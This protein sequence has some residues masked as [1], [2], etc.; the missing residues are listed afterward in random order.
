MSDALVR[1]LARG[2]IEDA[3]DDL[4]FALRSLRREPGVAA[5]IIATFALAI[6]ANA[7]MVG[8]VTRLM[9]VAPPGV[10]V[11]DA[12]ARLRVE[13][14]T[15]DGDRYA[16][17]TTSY[18]V[19]WAARA[20]GDAFSRCRRGAADRLTTG[21]GADLTEVRHRR[22]RRLL[23]RPRRAAGDR[24]LLRRRRRPIAS[25]SAVAVLSH[26]YWQRR[27]GGSAAVLGD[28]SW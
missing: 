9:M 19:F 14:T 6:G 28:H 13:V 20:L 10:S 1:G 23:P 26:A 12:L 15:A 8:L 4:R 27:Y 17:S 18:P 24:S 16:M 3:R 5:G 2:L 22:D 11:P 7:A 25:G 21:R